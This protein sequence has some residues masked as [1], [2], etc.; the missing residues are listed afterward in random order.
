MPFQKREKKHSKLEKQAREEHKGK[1][2]QWI[3][4]RGIKQIQ[5]KNEF[6][7]AD[8]SFMHNHTLHDTLHRMYVY[9]K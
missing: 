8:I 5:M 7:Y 3:L 9:L 4:K 6:K 2:E 1:E